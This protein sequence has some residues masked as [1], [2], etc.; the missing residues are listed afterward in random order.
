MKKLLEKLIEQAMIKAESLLA[1]VA[2][3]IMLPLNFSKD[4]KFNYAL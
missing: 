4:K 1:T 3:W 2:C